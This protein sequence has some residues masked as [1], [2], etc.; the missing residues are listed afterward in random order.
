M[1][2]RRTLFKWTGVAAL[3]GILAAV[4]GG[5]A[6][7]ASNPYYSGPVTDHFDG[8]RFFNPDG[9]PPGT[10]ADV[11]KWQ[12]GEGMTRWKRPVPAPPP[13]V[14]EER[15]EDL[16][17]TMVGHASLLLQCGRRNVL[18]DPVFS[19]RASPLPLGDPLRFNPPGIRFDDLPP[20]DLV[21]VSHNHYDHLDTS[22][23]KRLVAAHDPEI[24]TPLG[25]DTI[26]REAVPSARVRA[27]D[28]GDAVEVAGLRVTL[29]PAHHWSARG[30]NDRRK[31][32]WAAFVIE[33]GEG[34]P[35]FGRVYHVGDTGYHSGIN[36]RA[37]KA[38]HGGFR[39]AILPIGAYAPRWFMSPQHQD[40][41]E[42][43]AGFLECGA[44]HMVAH[45]WG[46]FQLTAEPWDEPRQKMNEAVA[47]QGVDPARIHMPRPGEHVDVPPVAMG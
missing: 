4:S 29:E 20:I 17:V 27:H 23:L 8:L 36:Y 18:L 5:R 41:A 9:T 19:D 25:N 34:T 22:S 12:F 2:T 11:I 35:D 30:I 13:T 46:T 24:V 3:G 44:G 43:L 37:A 40:P 33:A 15:V 32:L 42:A 47:E 39:L 16:R 14:P 10:L 38:K 26:I 31:A 45:H 28:W 1:T 7:R 21:L 6:A